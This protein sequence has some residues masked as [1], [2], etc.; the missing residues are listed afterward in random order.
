MA[1]HPKH[2]SN[3]GDGME[4]HRAHQHERFKHHV[5]ASGHASIPGVVSDEHGG[6]EPGKNDTDNAGPPDGSPH[7]PEL[8]VE[9]GEDPFHGIAGEY[10]PP[11]AYEGG[12]SPSEGGAHGPS[13][14][15]GG[16]IC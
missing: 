15:P 8:Y 4:H 7:N 6:H 14:L 3:D 16:S 13:N 10:M 5:K 1:M 2:D 12:R 9:H 11:R